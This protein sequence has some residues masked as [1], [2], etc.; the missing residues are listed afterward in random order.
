MISIKKLYYKI[1]KN[2]K[3]NNRKKSTLKVIFD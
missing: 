2:K 3:L 1:F